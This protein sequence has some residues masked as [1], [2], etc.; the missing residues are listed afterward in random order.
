MENAATG[1]DAQE[2]Q[3][4]SQPATEQADDRTATP[5]LVRA[6]W[7]ASG[8]RPEMPQGRRALA[9][10]TELLR[11]RPAP[12]RHNDWLKRIEELVAAAEEIHHSMKQDVA[13]NDASRDPTSSS[14]VTHF[15]LMAKSS[16]GEIIFKSLYKNKLA[17]S[18]FLEIMSIAIEGKK[19]IEELEAH[20]EEHETTIETMEGHERDYANEIAQLS[21]ALENEQTTK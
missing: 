4:S 12:D 9:M 6:S 14:I 5:S 8:V 1:P 17:C 13:L 18:N 11:Y 19:Y 21:Q 2:Q 20:L 10:A 15:F 3:G 7:S 16:K